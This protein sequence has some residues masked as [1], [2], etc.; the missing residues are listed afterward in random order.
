MKVL[1]LGGGA[2]EHAL[3]W[4]VAKSEKVA[5]VYVL[6]GNGGTADEPK[7]TNVPINIDD[8]GA[9]LRFAQENE[10][11]LTIVGPEKPLA[12]GI[13]DIFKEH[14]LV[15][16]GPSGCAVS[17]ET[18]K[19]FSKNLLIDLGIPTP[20][21]VLVSVFEEAEY[22]I[23]TLTPPFVVKPDGLTG[24]KGVVV[25]NSIEEGVITAKQMLVDQ[26]YGDAG[27]TILVEEYIQGEEATFTAIVDGDT[28]VPLATSRDHKQAQTGNIGPMTGGMGAFSPVPDIEQSSNMIAERYV[29][30]IIQWLK[31][32]GAPYVGFFYLGLKV[33]DGIPYVL[34]I[35]IRLGDPEAVPILM[36]LESDF[37]DLILAAT[38]Q[39]LDSYQSQVKWSPKHAVGVV[40]ASRG[41]P[42]SYQTGIRIHGLSDSYGKHTK[43]FHSGTEK[44]DVGTFTTGGR[45]LVSGALGDTLGQAKT[46]AYNPLYNIIS[47]NNMVFREDIGHDDD[48]RNWD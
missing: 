15:C 3:A 12:T 19:V 42:G 18:S 30:P 17:L 33:H 37:V 13:V 40:A 11:D 36:R 35:N 7:V 10:I 48:I 24:G 21:S 45:I 29:A 46:L 41:Y 14:G 20:R 34:E 38:E 1:I 39:R 32:E 44:R 23:R 26:I 27:Q 4:A 8:I 9:I 2:R 25:A 6:P 43:V 28:I 16:F 5:D 22:Y 47:F 31:D